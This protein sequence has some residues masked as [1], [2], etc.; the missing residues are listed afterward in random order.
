MNKDASVI[1]AIEAFL[2][3]NIV[4]I[5]G[6]DYYKDVSVAELY[7]T[8][9]NTLDEIVKAEPDRFPSDFLKILPN[10]NKLFSYGGVLMLGGQINTERAIRYQIKLLE[11]YTDKLKEITGLSVFDLLDKINRNT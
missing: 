3:E 9:I 8:D 2:N 10:G 6:E 5:D 4:I 1:L 11:Y 7:G